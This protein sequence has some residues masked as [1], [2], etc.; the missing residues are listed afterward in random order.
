NIQALLDAGASVR[1]LDE[2]GDTPLHNAALCISCKPCKI[3]ALL[4]AGA[5]GKAKNKEGKTPWDFAQD[6]EDLKGTKGYWA[7]NDAQH[8]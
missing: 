2:D 8:N 5:D 7:L 1:A 6:N 3:Q 4:T